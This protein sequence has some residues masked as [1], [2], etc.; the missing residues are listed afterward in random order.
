MINSDTT[1]INRK[2]D[3]DGNVMTDER[4]DLLLQ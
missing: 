4:Y 1:I 2:L 3:D